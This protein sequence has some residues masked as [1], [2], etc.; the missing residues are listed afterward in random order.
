MRLLLF[1]PGVA[2]FSCAECKKFFYDHTT[3][4][5]KTYN[6]GP[7]REKLPMIRPANV[8]TPCHQCP[9]E[10]PEK[11]SEHELSDRSYQTLVLY[12]RAMATGFHYLTKREKRDP[13]V[14]KHFVILE[15]LY[16][17]YERQRQSNDIANTLMPMMVRK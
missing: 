6:S 4:E 14:A 2:S 5:L 3:G 8:P 17:E 10:S 1:H 15:R 11:E 16:R 7:T 9:K 12:Q 13:L